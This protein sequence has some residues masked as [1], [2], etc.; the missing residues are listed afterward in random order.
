MSNWADRIGVHSGMHQVQ[1]LNIDQFRFNFAAWPAEDRIPDGHAEGRIRVG[2]GSAFEVR[3]WAR[4]GG[5]NAANA[6]M[7]DVLARSMFDLAE[8]V[9][10]PFEGYEPGGAL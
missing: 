9:P 8:W 1:P 7:R 10:D 4:T 6:V 3:L 2:V 5:I